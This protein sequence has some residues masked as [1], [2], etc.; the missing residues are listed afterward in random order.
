MSGHHNSRE[1]SAPHN[2]PWGRHCTWSHF[3][4]GES[5][6]QASSRAALSRPQQSRRSQGNHEPCKHHLPTSSPSP[7][8]VQRA[9]APRHSQCPPRPAGPSPRKQNSRRVGT[10]PRGKASHWP[11]ASRASHPLPR[12][13]WPRR[14]PSVFE[15]A[16]GGL[17]PGLGASAPSAPCS[18]LQV[19]GGEARLSL[20]PRTAPA[21]AGGT[22]IPGRLHPDWLCAAL[23]HRRFASEPPL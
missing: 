3:T 15:S 8:P 14:K 7:P 9:A 20:I 10:W 1:S 22:R 17:T 23:W 11:P 12:A 4:A 6:I 19:G 16:A 21:A 2:P 13:D 18:G 5:A